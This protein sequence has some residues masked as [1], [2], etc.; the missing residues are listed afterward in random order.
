MLGGQ[1]L[2]QANLLS[3]SRSQES[4]ADQTSIR[5]L[6]KSGFSYHAYEFNS[7]LIRA[8]DTKNA[9]KAWL[10]G[11]DIFSNVQKE[12]VDIFSDSTAQQFYQSTF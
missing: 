10:S 11:D 9:Q 7:A 6:K 3:F 2:S 4:F 1:H 12:T 5:L 8:L